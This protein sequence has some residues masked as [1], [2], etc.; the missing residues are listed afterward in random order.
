MLE[1]ES[2]GTG[3]GQ[4]VETMWG[5]G[6]KAKE[7]HGATADKGKSRGTISKVGKEEGE[8]VMGEKV[9]FEWFG[10][11]SSRVGVMAQKRNGLEASYVQQASA[12]AD[13]IQN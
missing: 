7:G 2:V 10:G 9:K 4:G 3:G 8:G 5:G 11:T 1:G 12:Y 13:T 6:A